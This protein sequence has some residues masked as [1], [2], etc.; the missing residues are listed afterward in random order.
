MT[1]LILFSI[2]ILSVAKTQ[3]L[4]NFGQRD[5]TDLHCQMHVIVH[6][7]VAMDPKAKPF[8]HLL[9]EQKKS[10]PICR[11][12]KNVLAAIASQHDVIYSTREMY[13]WFSWH[14]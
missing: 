9:Y 13:A 7:T 8:P 2:E 10:R 5:V 14:D 6:K 12:N 1:G 11:I 4:H 3:V